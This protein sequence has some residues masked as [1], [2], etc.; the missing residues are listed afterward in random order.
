MLLVCPPI[1]GNMKA[2]VAVY[3]LPTPGPANVDVAVIAFKAAY[4]V[5]REG[6]WV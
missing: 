4:I 6:D 1:E 2:Y 3:A 5:L